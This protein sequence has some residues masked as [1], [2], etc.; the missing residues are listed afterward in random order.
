MYSRYLSLAAKIIILIIKTK[1]YVNTDNQ[2][3]RRNNN[4]N[5]NKINDNN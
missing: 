2:T 4:D 5:G 3:V 1:K